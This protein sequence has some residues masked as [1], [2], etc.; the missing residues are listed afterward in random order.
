MPVPTLKLQT[1]CFLQVFRIRRGT[2]IEWP[3]QLADACLPMLAV[4]EQHLTATL[5]GAHS[6]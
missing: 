6:Y 3:K 5:D 4:L 2:T 1:A